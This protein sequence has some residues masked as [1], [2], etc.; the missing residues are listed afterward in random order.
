MLERDVH[1]PVGTDLVW[2]AITDPAALEDWFGASVEW[3]L[4]PG[5]RA[6]FHEPD[7]D[8]EGQ[9]D[10]VEPGRRLSFRWWPTD[11]GDDVSEVAYELRPEDDGTLLTITERRVAAVATD[12]WGPADQALLKVWTSCAMAVA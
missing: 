12:A 3:D 9:V 11:N 1:L 10:E 4:R 5:G 6:A 7:G 8:R 2:E